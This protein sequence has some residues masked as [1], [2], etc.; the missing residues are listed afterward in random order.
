MIT[1]LMLISH[2]EI[3]LQ[4]VELELGPYITAYRVISIFLSAQKIRSQDM[5]IAV[6][7]MISSG[8]NRNTNPLRYNALGVTFRRELCNLGEARSLVPSDYT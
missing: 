7:V 6:G 1:F 2:I 5:E 4:S 3:P 8:Q